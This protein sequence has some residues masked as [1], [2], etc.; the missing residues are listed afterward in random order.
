[1]DGKIVM[2]Q[3]DVR[4]R[5][6]V[7]N[8]IAGIEHS[9]G[10]TDVLINNAG[11]APGLEPAQHVALDDW[12]AMVNTNVKGLLYCTHAVL[13]GMVERDCGYIINLGSIA[14][15]YPYPGSQM[16]GASK[17]F[18][19]QCSLNLR[20]DLLGSRIRVSCIEPGLCGGTEF[21]VTRF[22]GDIGKT[23]DVY[24][25]TEPLTAEDIAQIVSC[26]IAL[27][28]HVNV[29]HLELM[30]TCQAFAPFSAARSA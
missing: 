12:K 24:Y 28:A 7:A 19:H 1:V 29:N 11:L 18:A 3:M 9:V 17:A 8:V 26:L 14:S 25:G 10:P 6:A 27:P 20:A 5:D 21:S 16:Y 15:S 2:R 13:P 22:K 4:R 30:P 23:N